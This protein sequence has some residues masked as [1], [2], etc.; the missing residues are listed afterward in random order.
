M[1]NINHICTSCPK[2]LEQK[3]LLLETS[4]SIFDAVC[5]LE[6]F[7]EKCAINCDK[8]K[9]ILDLSKDT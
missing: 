6:Y 8:I 5:D 4:E 7:Q 1:I 2:F 9:E 3:A